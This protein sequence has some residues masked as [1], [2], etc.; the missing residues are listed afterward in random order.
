MPDF[1][2]LSALDADL[3]DVRSALGVALVGPWAPTWAVPPLP[4][5]GPAPRPRTPTALIARPTS[6][7]TTP[8]DDASRRRFPLSSPPVDSVPTAETQV[9]MPG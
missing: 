9:R 2:T 7:A 4:P 3:A 6:D 1:R 5:A 8:P